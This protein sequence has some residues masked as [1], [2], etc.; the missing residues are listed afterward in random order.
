MHSFKIWN[1]IFEDREIIV[2]KEDWN[3]EYEGLHISSGNFNFISRL[4]KKTPK[5]PGYFVAIWKKD[6]NHKNTS[7]NKND[8]GDYLVVNI[9]DN[10]NEGQFVF[11]VS[12]LIE[13][14]IIQS[15]KSKGKMAF[16]VYPPWVK[17]LNKTAMVSQK[18][19]TEHFYK[20]GEYKFDM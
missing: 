20:M 15:E 12:V 13:K 18:W 1:K 4:A 11:P 14:G 9:L 3:K 6:E 19:Q 7:F 5:K 10:N 8:I 16:R 2:E 17:D